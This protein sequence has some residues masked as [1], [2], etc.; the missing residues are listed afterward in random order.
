MKKTIIA[1]MS[2]V[3]SQAFANS[4]W[5]EQNKLVG[6]IGGWKVYSKEQNLRDTPSNQNMFTLN[7]AI[8]R[9]LNDQLDWANY[10][11]GSESIS[12]FYL[13]TPAQ[14][15]ALQKRP[16]II[17]ETTKSYYELVALKEKLIHMEDMLDAVEAASELSSRMYKIGNINQLALLKQNKNLYKKRL[18]YKALQ[19]KFLEAKERFIQRMNFDNR[20]IRIDIDVR[21]PDPPKEPRKLNAKEL[22]AIELGV[23]N[24]LESV[25]TRSIARH[26]YESYLEKY[27]SVKSYKDEILPTQK[28]ISEENLLRYNG[29]LIDVFHLLEDA[30][31][32]SKT[33]IDYI[34]AN[35]AFLIQSARLEKDLIEVQ[36][37]FSN[38]NV[39]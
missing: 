24:N 9:A 12:D 29:M 13:L 3:A 21:L 39:R 1:V 18:E 15:S 32:Q 28:K 8:V 23:I 27:Q 22:K 31:T 20:N 10:L 30:E 11:S 14:R 4:A 16:L 35:A 6:E 34:D 26:S 36:I 33:V 2:L 19:V 37:D 5:I 17:Y 38:I 7:Q 25:K